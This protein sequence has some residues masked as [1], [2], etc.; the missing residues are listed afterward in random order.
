MCNKG[1]AV[2]VLVLTG[3][4]ITAADECINDVDGENSSEQLGENEQLN[5]DPL[6]PLPYFDASVSIPGNVCMHSRKVIESFP[7][8]AGIKL[9]IF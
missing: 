5:Q 9:T 2:I 7:R 8:C 1:N 6:S 4:Q 3:Q